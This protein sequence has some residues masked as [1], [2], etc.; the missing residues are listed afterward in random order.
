MIFLRLV[1]E[2]VPSA[3]LRLAVVNR[4]FMLLWPEN[5]HVFVIYC[6]KYIHD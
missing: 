6:L 5:I 2:L 4:N 3:Q 1:E